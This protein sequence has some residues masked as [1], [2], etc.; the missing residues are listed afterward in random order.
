MNQNFT[1]L[2]AH[3]SFPDSNQLLYTLGFLLLLVYIVSLVLIFM[4][5]LA[6]LNLLFNFRRFKKTKDNS[7]T[8]DFSDP[9]QIPFVTIQL[10]VYNELYVMERLLD[11]IVKL[12]YPC[13]K[14]EF[15]V[16]DDSTDESVATTALQI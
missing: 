6:Q 2:I 10:P 12:D 11:N 9:N 7:D 16:L 13:D 4:F 1:S 5:A 15:Q 14:L 3:M 8:F